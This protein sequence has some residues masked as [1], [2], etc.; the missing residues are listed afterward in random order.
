MKK[1]TGI[2]QNKIIGGYLYLLMCEIL[3]WFIFGAREIK[4]HNKKKWWEIFEEMKK[5]SQKKNPSFC[6]KEI[7]LVSPFNPNNTGHVNRNEYWQS[8]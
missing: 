4:T 5:I 7:G 8:E 6:I 3:M 2:D 1:W